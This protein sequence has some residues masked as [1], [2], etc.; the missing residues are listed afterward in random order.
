[1]FES[2]D[3]DRLLES[4]DEEFGGKLVSL[5]LN[6]GIRAGCSERDVL[7]KFSDYFPL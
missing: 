6:A 7:A 5:S 1:M 3:K 4:C 2:G